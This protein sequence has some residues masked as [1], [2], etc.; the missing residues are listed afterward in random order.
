MRSAQ[1]RLISAEKRARG[2]QATRPL[3]TIC[4]IVTKQFDNNGGD[5]GA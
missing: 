3:A 4:D 2:H 1:H 5:S